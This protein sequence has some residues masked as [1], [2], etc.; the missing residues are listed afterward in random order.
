MT[1]NSKMDP[2][3]VNNHLRW[4]TITRRLDNFVTHWLHTRERPYNGFIK[5]G[6]TDLMT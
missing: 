5:Q 3:L 4:N 6:K 2:L 1:L